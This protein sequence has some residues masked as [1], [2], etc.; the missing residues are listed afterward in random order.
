MPSREKKEFTLEIKAQKRAE[1][2][3]QGGTNGGAI[4]VDHI[5]PKYAGGSTEETNAQ[6]LTLPEH[7][8]KHFIASHDPPPGQNTDAEWMG[9]RHIIARMKLNEF[10]DFLEKVEPMIPILRADLQK[11]R[12]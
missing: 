8:Y 10:T 3:K 7:A 4:E 5:I 6:G 11:K 12:K 9:T 2:Y 1:R